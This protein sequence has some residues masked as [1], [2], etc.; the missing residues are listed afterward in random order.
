MDWSTTAS[1][2][3]AVGTATVGR[4]RNLDRPDPR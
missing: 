1:L 3:T 2:A 4:H